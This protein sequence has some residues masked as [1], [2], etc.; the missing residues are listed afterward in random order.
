MGAFL[1]AF[2]V[3]SAI[4][5]GRGSRA[6]HPAGPQR[7]TMVERQGGQVTAAPTTSN[8]KELK[9]IRIPF[10]NNYPLYGYKSM[11][12]YK[13]GALKSSSFRAL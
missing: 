12:F 9:E 1:G 11:D 5:N 8:K 4:Q 10:F 3:K 13:Y 7:S 2:R 6:P